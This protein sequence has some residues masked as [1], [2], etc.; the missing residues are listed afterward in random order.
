MLNVFLCVFMQSIRI[1][2]T[3][4][5][6]GLKISNKLANGNTQNWFQS[7]TLFF[8]VCHIDMCVCVLVC[9]RL[10]LLYYLC[11]KWIKIY[12][13]SRKFVLYNSVSISLIYAFQSTSFCIGKS[14]WQY[15]MEV[16]INRSKWV[17]T[18]DFTCIAVN[19]AFSHP[20]SFTLFSSLTTSE[21]EKN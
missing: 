11:S 12:N 2:I 20:I 6:N 14:N 7:L 8:S 15:N 10:L 19:I 5:A 4:C 1:C 18:L 9:M 3:A 17:F 13:I 16:P 21:D